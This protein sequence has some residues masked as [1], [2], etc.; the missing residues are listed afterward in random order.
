M[1]TTRANTLNKLAASL[2]PIYGK[3]EALSIAKLSLE[4]VFGWT[5]R[6]YILDSNTPVEINEHTLSELTEQ[7]LT[8][9]PVQYVLGKARFLD[10]ELNV[11]SGVLIPRDET[12]LLVNWIKQENSRGK[13]L[14]IGTG[15]GAISIALAMDSC[16]ELTAVDVSEDALKIACSNAQLHG[17]D[18][19]LKQ[20]DILKPDADFIETSRFDIIVS[21]PPYIPESEKATMRNNV[22]DFEPHL[23]L[24]VPDNDPLLFYREIAKLALRILNNTGKLYFEIHENYASK[25]VELLENLGYTNIE[26]RKDINDKARMIRCQK[27]L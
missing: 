7:L 2:T 23:A 21:N 25:T 8:S 5:Q 1:Q 17:L 10:L 11:A 12:E 18:I 13:I 20:V 6:D 16:F 22:L 14:D 9:K 15:S 24:F 19:K 3:R 4:E 26:L 27:N